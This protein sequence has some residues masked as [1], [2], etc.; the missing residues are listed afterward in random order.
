LALTTVRSENTEALAN[1]YAG[2]PRQVKGCGRS[3][4]VERHIVGRPESQY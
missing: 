2:S 3:P 1:E 4:K